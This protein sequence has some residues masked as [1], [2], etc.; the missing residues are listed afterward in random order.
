MVGSKKSSTSHQQKSPL[1]QRS[2]EGVSSHHHGGLADVQNVS[3]SNQ[4]QQALQKKLKRDSSF[5]DAKLQ[6]Q[7]AASSKGLYL[8]MSLDK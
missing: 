6:L 4:H 3:S 2:I 1:N 8:N 7:Q 5:Q